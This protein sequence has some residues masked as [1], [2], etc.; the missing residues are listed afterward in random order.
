MKTI[1]LCILFI[2]ILMLANSQSLINWQNKDLEKDS[3]FGISTEKAYAELL[4]CKKAKPVIVAII[5]SG[6]DTLHE[7][8]N[9]NL[10]TNPKT[11]SHGWNYIG[12]ET[13]R[14]DITN[15][16]SEGKDF[17]DSL[18]YTFVP[19]EYRIGY[20]NYRKIEPILNEKIGTM[21]KF[22]QQLKQYDS[23][24]AKELVNLAQFHIK[25]GL[26]LNNTEA[27]TAL[28]NSDVSPDKVGPLQNSNMGPFHG[29]HVAGIIGA[30]R[31][32]GIGMDGISNCVQLM[33]LKANGNIRELRDKALANAIHFAVDNGAKVIN[34]S[35]GK[36]Y[37]WN[38]TAVDNAVKYAMQNDVIIIHGAGNDG[39][40][41]DQVNYFPNRYYSDGS[42]QANAWIE[43]AA[44]SQK[45][46]SS[47]IPTFTNYGKTRVDV[48][49]P[50]V[51]IYSTI[52]YSKYASWSGTSM[53]APVVAGLAALIRA[54]FPQL[55]AIQV[56]DIILNAVVKRKILQDKCISGGVVNAY[57]SLK[58][59]SHF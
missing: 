11:G 1:V 7:D 19:G 58:L 31:G 40:D 25:H 54:Y 59:A 8:L 41:L 23:K 51:Q 27:D 15:L 57:N 16:I 10:W 46:D 5:D 33:I 42:G 14:E 30:I 13:G 44:S 38:K 6:I 21:E 12:A 50:G 2:F 43:V 24:E 47:L 32:N 39:R 28:G 55:T 37:T 35:M 45:D 56:K 34:I 17:Y 22:I 20:Q 49:A 3:V 53:A 36:Y 26:N 29:T 48:F 52:P 18:S 4:K 9:K